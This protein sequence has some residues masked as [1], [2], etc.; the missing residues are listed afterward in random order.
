MTE[1]NQNFSKA[2]RLAEKNGKVYIFK[3]NV[4][5]FVLVDIVEEPYLDLTDDEKAYIVGK[6]VMEKYHDAFVELAK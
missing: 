4:P 5:K 3:N 6:R 2:A 1:A